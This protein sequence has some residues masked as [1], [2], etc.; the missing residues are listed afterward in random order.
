MSRVIVPKAEDSTDPATVKYIDKA[1]R[2]TTAAKSSVRVT[3]MRWAT[4]LFLR[5]GRFM[6]GRPV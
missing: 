4:E 2:P 3:N 6:Y 1:I 5:S